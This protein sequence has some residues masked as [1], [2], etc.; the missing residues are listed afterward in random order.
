[1]STQI[2]GRRRTGAQIVVPALTLLIMLGTGCSEKETMPAQEA[3]M[4]P[5]PMVA[6]AEAP[7][8]AEP[9]AMPEPAEAPAAAAP[10]PAAG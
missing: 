1:M 2:T 5:A 4:E 3:A 10:E 9:A 6:E 7:A 8:A